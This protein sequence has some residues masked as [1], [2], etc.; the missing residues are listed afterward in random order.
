MAE[1]LRAR[2]DANRVHRRAVRDK[3][4][5]ATAEAWEIYLRR[6]HEMPALVQAKLA[7]TSLTLMK[8]TR[9]EGKS[10]AQ[11]FWRYVSS[12]D[13]GSEG[14]AEL[15]DSVTG[16]PTVDLQQH[17]TDYLASLY[18]PPNCMP[19]YR[20]VEAPPPNV[21]SEPTGNRLGG[22]SA[23]HKPRT[24]PHWHRHSHGTGWHSGSP[25]EAA[26]S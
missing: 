20:Q 11:K 1:A 4:F 25:S 24:G 5:E 12:L 18:G 7:A 10:A 21:V 13:R 23:R 26:R 3:D 8:S 17:V 22:D 14:P 16:Q 2:R 19:V 15:A 9:A 6:K